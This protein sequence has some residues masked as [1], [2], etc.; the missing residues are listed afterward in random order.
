MGGYSID[1]HSPEKKGVTNHQFLKEGSWYSIPYRCLVINQV[2]NL[3]V[4]GKSLSATHD[5]LAAVGVTPIAVALGQAGG[6][7]AAIVSKSGIKTREIYTN[8]L[9]E[10]MKVQ[11]AFLKEYVQSGEVKAYR[12]SI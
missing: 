6:K 3:I 4:V 1:I 11:G 12:N 10:K 7:A 5:A 2:D 8:L 9:R